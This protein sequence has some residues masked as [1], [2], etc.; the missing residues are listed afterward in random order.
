MKE[1]ILL[2]G[3][4][5]FLGSRLLHKLYETGLYKIVVLKRSFSNT[6]RIADLLASDEL[7][8]IDIDKVNDGFFKEY[9]TNHKVDVIIHSATY[10]GRGED[11]SITKVLETNLMF[12]LSLLEE[13]VNHGL[14]LFINT[15]SY[16]NKQN[17]TYRTLLDYSLS[18]KTLN[19]WLEYLSDKV[20]VANLR[21]EHIYGENDSP[22][23]F[24]ESMIRKIAIEHVEN[25]SLTYGQQKRD[26]IY[27][28]DV[29]DAFLTILQNYQK[30]AFHY[31]T[32][33]VGTG[34]NLSIRDFVESIKRISQSSTELEFGKLPYR[35]DEIMS[36]K[37]DINFLNN[38]GWQP[39]VSV[40]DGLTKI[41]KAYKTKG[42][43]VTK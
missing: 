28:D 22:A 14:K 43:I 34:T 42:L 23:K 41:I 10:Y 7:E 16:F 18:K 29:C 25:I 21:L 30:F 12:P 19:L 33:D 26:F 20:K 36:S 24:V 6:A 38:L 27:I 1:T 9:F 4:T 2:T 31:I 11:A 8:Y 17:Q 32:F 5:G 13:A 15:D 40:E 3:G 39:K 37:A 35:E